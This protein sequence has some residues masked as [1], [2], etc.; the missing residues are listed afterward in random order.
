[1]SNLPLF[2]Q[3]P[4]ENNF[5]PDADVVLFNGDANIFTRMIPDRA[6][7]LVVTPPPYNL[8]KAYENR[9]GIESYLEQ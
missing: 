9:T 8:G 5:N 7:Q 2:A 4:I 1:M 3:P 6:V